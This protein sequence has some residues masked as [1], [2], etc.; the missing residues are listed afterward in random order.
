MIRVLFISLLVIFVAYLLR[1][2]LESR[3]SMVENMAKNDSSSSVVERI[4]IKV[5]GEDGVEW[6]VVGRVLSLQGEQV[7]LDAPVF[8]S[9][10][11][12]KISARR[13]DLNRSTGIGT[14]E[15]DVE[16]TS[17]EFYARVDKARVDLKKSIISDEGSIYVKKGEN[18]ISGEGYTIDLKGGKVII[19]RV[20]AEIK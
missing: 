4:S 13:S 3:R 16:L 2:N 18:W 14:L 1:I 10:K 6:N 19:K 20:R 8:E 9:S 7:Y 5:Y 12:D 11:G 17:A 15:G